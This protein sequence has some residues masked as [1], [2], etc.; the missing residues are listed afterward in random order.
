MTR[1]QALGPHHRGGLGRAVGQRVVLGHD[2]GVV[3]S[4]VHPRR[5]IRLIH[6]P[7]L[8]RC[9]CRHGIRLGPPLSPL[10]RARS[11]PSQCTTA[12]GPPSPTRRVREP[13]GAGGVG[14]GAVCVAQRHVADGD[15]HGA[16]QLAFEWGAWS[17]QR[18]GETDGGGADAAVACELI[19]RGRPAGS[20]QAR[21]LPIDHEPR[22]LDRHEVRCSTRLL[23]VLG[24]LPWAC[25]EVAIGGDA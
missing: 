8:P 9:S 19:R 14:A 6:T 22:S 17:K 16:A 4:V 13:A 11:P 5:R 2:R 25:A 1:L 15:G 3:R 24:A 21:S 10:G 20:V 23:G 7:L 12:R 18:G